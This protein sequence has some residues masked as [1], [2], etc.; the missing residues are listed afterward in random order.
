MTR[1]QLLGARGELLAAAFLTRTGLEVLAHNW[2]SAHGEIDLVAREGDEVVFVEVKT[3]V[4]GPEVAPDVAVNAAKLARLARLAEAY[5]RDE[6]T[7]DA[8]WRVDVIAIVLDARG[9]V[10]SLEHLRGAFL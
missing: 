5:L 10:R 3:R 2:R 4:G 7:P 1:A 9:D 8:A 6:G